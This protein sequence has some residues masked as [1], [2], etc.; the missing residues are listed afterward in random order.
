VTLYVD[1]AQAA[2]TA[3][4]SLSSYTSYSGYWHLGYAP[5]ATTGLT[6][7]YFGGSLSDFVVFNASPIPNPP[8]TTNPP[9]ASAFATFA[10]N[11]TDWWPLNDSGSTT[12]TGTLPVVGVGSGTSASAACKSLDLGWSFTSPSGSATSSAVSL[13]SWI[14]TPAS[15]STVGAPGVG[16]TQSAA[17]TVSHD[18]LY[19]PYVA[20]LHLWV[21]MTSA[22]SVS[23]GTRWSLTFG[24]TPS[25]STT[26]IPTT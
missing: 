25:V 22:I 5:T 7:S 20:G 23:L 8:P 11:A 9:S 17:I 2:T 19:D 16:N 10:S 26:I 14:A 3:L 4:L 15:I 21:P 13:Y 1:G 18:G 6:S 24:W 12:F